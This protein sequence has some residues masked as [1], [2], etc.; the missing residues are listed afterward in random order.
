M[1]ASVIVPAFNA[2]KTLARCLAALQTQTCSPP[3]YEIIVVNDGSTDATL[4]PV[5]SFHPARY[6]S[7]P[8]AGA[9]TARNRGASMARGDILLFTD[10]DC[11]PQPD[12]IEKM[13]RAFD[14]ASVSG[15]KGTYQTRQPEPVARFVQLEYEEKYARMRRAPTI[16]FIDTYSAAYRRE[17]FLEHHGFDESFPTASVEDQEFS[18]RL[19]EL[20][21]KMIFV[22]DAIV[23]HEH[24]VSLG[25]YWRRKF[26]IG[27]WKVRVHTRHPSKLWRDS[28]TPPTQKLQTM[29]FL[30]MLALGVVI[31]FVSVAWVGLLLLAILFAISALPLIVFMARRDARVA[32]MAPMMIGLR[33]G[34]LGLGLAAG[35][36]GEFGWR[37]FKRSNASNNRIDAS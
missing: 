3:T 30:A 32:W 10:A 23:Y 12:W 25:A 17:I 29:L 37:W 16:D 9:A 27:Y 19:A 14:D 36:I 31:P 1:R 33:A 13:L 35:M 7:I 11:E 4:Q 26:W 5:S 8:H 6:I 24:P 2:Q 15:A 34:A 28:H 18:F 21:H 22:P 20:G